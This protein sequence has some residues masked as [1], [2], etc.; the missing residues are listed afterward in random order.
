[1]KDGYSCGY[2]C[3]TGGQQL[4][5]EKRKG[6]LGFILHKYKNYLVFCDRIKSARIG[7]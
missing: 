1:M 2:Y 7:K 3:I 4:Q 5:L 6:N